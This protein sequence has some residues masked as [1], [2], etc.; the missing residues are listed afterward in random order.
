MVY[1]RPEST[2]ASAEDIQTYAAQSLARFKIPAEI[3]FSNTPL[4]RG[5]TEKIDKKT[6]K[7]GVLEA[8]GI[9]G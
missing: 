9:S 6:V 2:G 8:R 5:A 1:L 4:P 7:A 3:L